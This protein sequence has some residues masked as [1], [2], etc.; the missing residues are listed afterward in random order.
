MGEAKRKKQL[1][2]EVPDHATRAYAHFNYEQVPLSNLYIEHL[3]KK[4]SSM[5]E[6]LGELDETKQRIKSNDFSP[7]EKKQKID[8]ES[9]ELI[10]E[11]V[12]VRLVDNYLLYLQDIC[13]LIFDVKPELVGPIEIKPAEVMKYKD[14]SELHEQ[15]KAKSTESISRMKRDQLFDVLKKAGLESV[16]RQRG[17]ATIGQALELRDILTHKRGL[18]GSRFLSGQDQYW[19]LGKNVREYESRHGEFIFLMH[20]SVVE[21]DQEAIQKFSIPNVP[22]KSRLEGQT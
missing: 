9:P 16:V 8:F 13:L 17:L 15:L 4:V 20:N 3:R 19:K 18:W 2:V 22:V 7:R 1:L 10:K 6:L 21:I 14:M 5:Q 12:F 11:S